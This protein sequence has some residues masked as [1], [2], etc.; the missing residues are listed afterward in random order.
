[1]PNH[2]GLGNLAALA[3]QD[4]NVL[5]T[6]FQQQVSFQQQLQ[7]YMELLHS[8]ANSLNQQ[9]NTNANN[10]QVAAQIF[11]VSH[12]QHNNTIRIQ[13][14][15]LHSRKYEFIFTN[16]FVSRRLNRTKVLLH[17]TKDFFNAQKCQ[18]KIS[19]NEFDIFISQHAFDFFPCESK[20]ISEHDSYFH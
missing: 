13:C 7:N 8:S 11:Q 6:A 5:Q 12:L 9:K 4:M 15:L 20:C 2:L 18:I 14:I 1:M 17:W 19:E 10:V 16:T 3:S